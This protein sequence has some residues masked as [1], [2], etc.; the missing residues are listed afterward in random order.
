MYIILL[1]REKIKAED[2]KTFANIVLL[3]A[4]VYYY[5]RLNSG[6]RL[7]I[8]AEPLIHYLEDLMQDDSEENIYF[9]MIQVSYSTCAD[10]TKNN[11]TITSRYFSCRYSD[12]V[13]TFMQHVQNN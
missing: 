13:K 11:V 10:I 5:M 9:I 7:K 4:E 8:L 1:A 6:N 3:H 12:L 2:K